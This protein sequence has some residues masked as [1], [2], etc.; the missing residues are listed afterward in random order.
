MEANKVINHL[1]KLA[2]I[3]P[4]DGGTIEINLNIEGASAMRSFLLEAVRLIE[5]G[6]SPLIENKGTEASEWYYE[7]RIEIPG[8]RPIE[9][10]FGRNAALAMQNFRSWFQYYEA[11]NIKEADQCSIKLWVPQKN[12]VIRQAYFS[13]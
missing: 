11:C 7:V 4:H 10:K 3:I 9:H 2:A 8:E 12:N 5:A 1:Q 13:I 6:Q